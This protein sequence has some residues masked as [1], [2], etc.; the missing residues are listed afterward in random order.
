M[1]LETE[2]ATRDYLY[3]RL[4]AVAEHMENRAL[5]FAG[6]TRDTNAAKL[7]SR[8]ANHPYNTWLQLEIALSPYK[9]RLRTQSP[10]TLVKLEK[11]SQDIMNA[12]IGDDFRND[13]KLS[14]EFLLAY[15][16]QTRELW[17]HTG[18][19]ASTVDSASQPVEVAAI[20]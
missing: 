19:S 10:G 14:G 4:L 7:L 1:S 3:G 13:K 11:L 9:S 18:A 12:F 20:D 5:H 2:R 17:Q 8:F 6:E 16:C 15:H